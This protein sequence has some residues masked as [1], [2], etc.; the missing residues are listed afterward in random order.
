MT[1]NAMFLHT[2]HP[3]S[4]ILDLNFFQIHW[5][6]FIITLA[7]FAGFFVFYQLA[8]KNNF[9]KEQIFNLIFWLIIAS[10]IGGRLYHVFS[11]FPYYWQHPLQIFYLWQG[12]L[13]IFGAIFGMMLIIYLF[14]R[15]LLD[16]HSRFPVCHPRESGDP[17]IVDYHK[18]SILDSHLR[19][20]DKNKNYRLQITDY[21]LFFLDSL[22]P[23]LAIGQAIGRWGNYFNQELYGLPTN[24]VL[25]I[26]ID[27]ANRLS[28]Y[29]NFSFFQP[30]FLYE[31]I[32]C[33]AVA[34]LMV[35][36]L[37]NRAPMKSGRGEEGS[38]GYTPGAIFFLY[39]IFYSTWRFFIEFL[40]L[41]PQPTFLNLRL[42]QWV[43]LVLIIFS[44]VF[45]FL[46]KRWYNKNNKLSPP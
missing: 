20:N 11:E 40:R 34:V 28:G 4:I 10:I 32:F 35:V 19:E 46:L 27:F 41:D 29:E 3:S 44:I 17:K 43:S 22:A 12:G 39:I 21:R 42:G 36:I 37:T 1:I 5:Y 2:Y 33:L 8:K 23:A 38:R 31:S 15:H 13:G 26:P 45:Y 18:I 6:G 30:L 9:T 25:G 7:A 14:S 24:S 16:C